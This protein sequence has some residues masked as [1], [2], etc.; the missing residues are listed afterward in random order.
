MRTVNPQD[1]E[2]LAKLLDGRGGLQE[3]LDEAFTRASNLGVSGQLATLRP[4]RSWV[5]DT[6]PDLRNRAITARLEDG[7]PEAGLRWAGFS[8]RELKA[9]GGAALRAETIVLANSVA[10]SGDPGAEA[11]RRRDRE[12]IDDW[13]NRLAGHALADLTG[14]EAHEATVTKFVELARDGASVLSV[15]GRT[16]LIGS[17]LAVA[18]GTNAFGSHL[19]RIADGLKARDS[20]LAKQIGRV[21]GRIKVSPRAL[22]AP[23]SWLPSRLGAL[24]QGNTLYRNLSAVPVLSRMND[25]ALGH[26]YD[27]AR[28]VV[29]RLSPRTNRW[30]TAVLGDDTL[31]RSLNLTNRSGAEITRGAQAGLRKAGFALYREARRNSGRFASTKAALAGTAKVTGFLRAGNILLSA[32]QTV[33][34]LNNLRLQGNPVD[35]FQ[36]K[37]AGYVADVAEVG[38]NASMTAATIA[39]NPITF[40]AVAVTGTVYVTAK[41]VEHW[42]EVK[43]GAQKAGRWLGSKAGA[44]GRD[45]VEGAKNLARKAN[46]AN[47]F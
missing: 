31:T 39:P 19:S 41:V 6:A 47:W 20:P 14:L 10:A 12:S 32:G 23:G 7:D 5:S 37:G 27:G 13:L 15:G 18:Q 25:L 3:R 30:L 21:V 44:A 8:D 24:F 43:G 42:D 28:Q 29:G 40:G 35:A 1:L 17:S 16:L 38:F 4:L 9:Y 34:G 33:Y 2:Q 11:F 36:R 26:G 46:P 22:S 45:M